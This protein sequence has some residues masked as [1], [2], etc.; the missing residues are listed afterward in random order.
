MLMLVIIFIG[1]VLLMLMLI[2]VIVA[3]FIRSLT[4]VLGGLPLGYP[5]L[6]SCHWEVGRH[7][8]SCNN[9]PA[10]DDGDFN[11][12]DNEFGVGK[13]I[14]LND[15]NENEFVRVSSASVWKHIKMVCLLDLLII[16]LV[17]FIQK[18]FGS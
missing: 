8:F 4:S 3:V 5:F 17:T 12:N 15:F 1:M 14:N 11:D 18:S 7:P 13:H 10:D 6:G 16:R 9:L 2:I